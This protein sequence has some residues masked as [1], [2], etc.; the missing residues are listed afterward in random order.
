MTTMLPL[1]DGALGLPRLTGIVLISWSFLA[2]D[3]VLLALS[4]VIT[5]LSPMLA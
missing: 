4:T 2:T 5:N 3:I 1:E